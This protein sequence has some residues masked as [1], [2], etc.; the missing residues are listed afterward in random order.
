M[1]L[2][3]LL[4]GLLAADAGQAPQSAPTR[5]AA[6][7]IAQSGDYAQALAAF[8]QIVTANPQ[9]HHARLWIAQL[10][11]WMGH[12]E[13]AEPVYRSVVMQNYG[14]SARIGL[15]DALTTLGRAEEAL[16]VLDVAEQEAPEDVNVLAA[17]GR[18]HRAAGNTTLSMGYLQRAVMIAP[19]SEN[20]LALEQTRAIYDH[21]IA[22]TSLFENFNQEDVSATRNSDFSA[23][24][25]ISD[26]LRL[27]GRGQ[28]QRK[29]G[30]TDQRGGGGI[31]WRQSA[32]TTWA[33]HA[34]VGPGNDVL[35]RTDATVALGHMSGAAEWTLG[36]RF[37]GFA[38][39]D[40]SVLSP[41]VNW[42]PTGTFS[43]GLNYH[44][45]VTS[46]NDGS[47]SEIVHSAGLRGSY[48]V[49]PRVW[50]TA[51]YAHGIESLDTLTRDRLV[52]HL[53]ANTASG[54]MQFD[55]PTMTSFVT[56]YE[57]QWREN[58]VKMGRFTIAVVQRF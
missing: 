17:L 9:D 27:V 19:T 41:A 11:M 38:D 8:R 37:I 3:L 47:A 15:A 33:A 48:M 4:T 28:Y 58:D 29:F 16:N 25:R 18:A 51:G 36:Y 50:V 20:R 43:I 10:H 46:L 23:N 55:L 26:A 12:P 39:A 31:E 22:S 34:L 7:E 30:V 54:G 56:Q 44:A 1:L 2:S 57:H 53:R 14:N 13:L 40:V 49:Y 45:A 35:P 32:K 5:E 42:W 21:R 6:I 24:I 52:D